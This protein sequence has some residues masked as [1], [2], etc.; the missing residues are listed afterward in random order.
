MHD[1]DRTGASEDQTPEKA[2]DQAAALKQKLA[3]LNLT[4]SSSR[5]PPSHPILKKPRGPSQS[6]PRPTARFAGVPD[7]EEDTEHQSS[8]SQQ[9]GSGSGSGSGSGGRKKS[10]SQTGKQPPARSQPPTSKVDRKPGKKFVA[11]KAT[12]KR[13]PILPRRQSSQSSNGSV[14]SDTSSKDGKSSTPSQKTRL[15]EFLSSPNEDSLSQ[16]EGSLRLPEHN[17]EPVP[18]VKSLGKQPAKVSSPNKPTIVK[19]SPQ[20]DLR[21]GPRPPASKRT[22]SPLIQ[23]YTVHESTTLIQGYT[24]HESTSVPRSRLKEEQISAKSAGKRPEAPIRGPTAN[25][26]GIHEAPAPV[27]TVTTV[28][29]TQA[30]AEQSRESNAVEDAGWDEETPKEGTKAK[31]PPSAPEQAA[32]APRMART[33][34][35][36][37]KRMSAAEPVPSSVFKSSSVIS[38]SKIAVTGGFDFETPRPRR[39]DDENLPPLGTLEPDIPKTSVLDSKFSPTPPSQGPALPMARSKSQLML[40]L[41]RDKERS[42]R[43]RT[44]SGSWYSKGGGK[45]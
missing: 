7:S 31:T 2:H 39:S 23:G 24:V 29:F 36:E 5:P 13:R 19:T 27:T 33:H 10:T 16:N 37:S 45:K 40:L 26:L 30:T 32:T 38:M 6:G 3:Q 9:T 44:S 14:T 35:N 17:E 8:D 42:V 1:S 20:P 43:N 25:P 4:P 28:Q 22:S 21:S 34:S 41:E 18:S 12:G 15:Q 11:S